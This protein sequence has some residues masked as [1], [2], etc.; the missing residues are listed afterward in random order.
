[1]CCSIAI[2]REQFCKKTSCSNQNK[3]NADEFLHKDGL[4]QLLTIMQV[5]VLKNGKLRRALVYKKGEKF[6]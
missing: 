6:A 5:M 1:M 3:F 4:K 2:N